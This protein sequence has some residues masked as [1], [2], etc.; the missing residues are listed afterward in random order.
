MGRGQDTY[1]IRTDIATIKDSAKG[2]ILWKFK[3]TLKDW[4]KLNSKM[5][6]RSLIT[7]GALGGTL[8]YKCA[9]NIIFS[10]IVAHVLVNKCNS[11]KCVS[12]QVF[13]CQ[14]YECISSLKTSSPL[15]HSFMVW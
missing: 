9:L 11:V 2:P 12:I 6:G 10:V 4:T 5:G 8:K 1:K 7:S 13:K 15:C 3:K 14:D